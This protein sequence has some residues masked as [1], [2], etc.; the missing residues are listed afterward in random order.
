LFEYWLG[1]DAGIP[2]YEP[3]ISALSQLKNHDCGLTIM[4]GN[5]DFLLGDQFAHETS[6]N[7][8]IDD[9]LEITQNNHNALLM[10]GDTLCTDDVEYLQFRSLVRNADWQSSFLSLSI[11]DRLKKAEELR[12]ASKQANAEKQT[13]IMDVNADTVLATVQAYPQHVLIHGHTHRPAVHPLTVCNTN[14]SR[15]VLGD[16]RGD[17]AQYLV[18]NAEGLELKEY[19]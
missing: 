16:W 2:L 4:H 1:D 15:Y 12:R 10:H 13:A 5:R 19:R 9:A 7:L 18:W 11:H 14:T 3:V 8:F 17:S 6:A